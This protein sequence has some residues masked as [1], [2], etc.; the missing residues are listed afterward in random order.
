VL[1]ARSANALLDTVINTSGI[2]RANALVERNGEIILDGGGSGTV[3][4][5]G[6]VQADGSISMTGGSVDIAGVV[7]TG[8]MSIGALS[9]SISESAGG[10]I[11]ANTLNTNSAGATTLSG[12]NQISNFSG[13]SNG[14]LSLTN[15]GAL[16][17]N[18]FFAMLGDGTLTNAGDVSVTG[19]WSSQ[20]AKIDT[21]GNLTVTGSITS[22]GFMEVDVGGTLTVAASGQLPPPTPGFFNTPRM[23]SL[24][25]LAGQDIKAGG[26]KVTASDGAFATISNNGARRRSTPLRRRSWLA[27]V[28]SKFAR[29]EVSF[30]LTRRVR[31]RSAISVPA[32]KK[33]LSQ[34]AAASM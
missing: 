33:S 2:V 11:L 21:T 1:A 10:A 18:S 16:T 32:I 22:N 14:A 19:G 7:S 34:A 17:V 5:A 6:T 28:V 25:S 29:P 31:R 3:Q 24:T 26:I 20:A 4:V 27:A 9:G 13:F 30:R 23:A 15:S 12:P 8:T